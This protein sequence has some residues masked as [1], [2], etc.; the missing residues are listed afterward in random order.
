[1]IHLIM[2]ISFTVYNLKQFAQNRLI[3]CTFVMF[4]TMVLVSIFGCFYC[5][6]SRWLV[7]HKY[8][9]DCFFNC[10]LR[11]FCVLIDQ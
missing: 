5:K 3:L 8:D 4:V 9:Y 10:N 7:S 6:L 2:I 1:M 11:C